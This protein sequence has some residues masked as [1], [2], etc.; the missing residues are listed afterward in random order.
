M[1]PARPSLALLALLALPLVWGCISAGS[2]T[3]VAPR[4]LPTNQKLA[5][6]T[7]AGRPTLDE[8]DQLTNGF[9]DRYYMVVGSAVDSI[10]KG[11]PDAV[12]RRIAHRIKTNGVLALNDI[13]SSPDPYSQGLDL[14][15]AVTLQNAV[16][17]DDN[18]AVEVFGE[19]APVLIQALSQMRRDAWELA[20]RF[21]V[22]SQLETLDM[23]IA[24]WHN[25]HPEVDQV[26]FVKFD[27]FAGAR[28]QALIAGLREGKGLMAPLV[29]M[30]QEAREYRRLAERAFWYS[31]R[32][33][34]IA[35]IQ[36]EATVNELLAVPEAE[37]LTASVERAS[38]TGERVGQM[39]VDFPAMLESRRQQLNAMMGETQRLIGAVQGLTGTVNATLVTLDTTMRTA[40]AIVG[41]YYTPP[42]PGA[43]GAPPGRPFDIREYTATLSKLEDVVSGVN[44]LASNGDHLLQSP[45][46]ENL[47]ALADARIDRLFFHVYVTVG[48]IF[49]LGLG[50]RFIAARL[51]APAS[52]RPAASA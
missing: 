10:K 45:G 46:V 44:Q 12:Q 17:V 36:A 34:N 15:V 1:K 43:S 2:T 19:R 52:R 33:P 28:A 49:L 25:A 6:D 40:D 48:L 20:G 39:M 41:R 3:A 4:E 7:K 31:K 26:A 11:N 22:Q 13:A 32:A 8:L 5:G 27:D 9:A 51:A 23:L 29:E 35:S 42:A 21:L 14:V 37:R 16:W 38:L 24:D 18:R 50:F 30:S 47:T